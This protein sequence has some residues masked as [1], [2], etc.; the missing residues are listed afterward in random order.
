VIHLIVTLHRAPDDRFGIEGGESLVVLHLGE[1]L[2]EF[3]LLLCALGAAAYGIRVVG[4][5]S[6]RLFSA[7]PT[8]TFTG[9]GLWPR[10]RSEWLGGAY[11]R[12]VPRARPSQARDFLPQ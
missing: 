10:S 5:D 12:A 3:V 8:C 9:A 6:N 11:E 1:A 7:E 2:N 4:T